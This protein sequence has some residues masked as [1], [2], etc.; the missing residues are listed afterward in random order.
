MRITASGLTY[1]WCRRR[2]SITAHPLS[3][4]CYSRY[5]WMAWVTPGCDVGPLA[6]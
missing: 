6:M 5:A 1:S 2:S 3:L 4:V